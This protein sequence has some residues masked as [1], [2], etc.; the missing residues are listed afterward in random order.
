MQLVESRSCL[1]QPGG[2]ARQEDRKVHAYQQLAHRSTSPLVITPN[3][4]EHQ[5]KS[6]AS[7][8]GLPAQGD[9]GRQKHV[10]SFDLIVLSQ[11]MSNNKVFIPPV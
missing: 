6:K 8:M 3:A 11:L 1:T 4:S 10:G 7:G 5:I 9:T 2:G